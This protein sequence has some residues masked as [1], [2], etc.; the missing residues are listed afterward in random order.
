MSLDHDFSLKSGERQTGKSIEEIRRDH[1]ARYEL[2]LDF[3]KST[4]KR[5]ELGLDIFAGTGYGAWLLA[6]ALNCHIWAIDGSREAV[7]FGET[8]F[9]HPAVL[10]AA[11]IFPFT[12]PPDTFDFIC[13]FESME[14]VRDEELFLTT[15]CGSL[16]SRGFLFLSMPNQD[17]LPLDPARHRYHFRHIHHQEFI[18]RLR[19]TYPS[20]VL[21]DWFGQNVYNGEN[22]ALQAAEMNCF[23]KQEGQFLIFTLQKL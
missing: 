1:V 18:E 2:A 20:L 23:S 12:L 9:N 19:T 22:H 17:L 3:L 21:L 13:C 16:K 10:L 8:Y 14:H 7:T 6:S 15:I 5:V 11:K 4:R